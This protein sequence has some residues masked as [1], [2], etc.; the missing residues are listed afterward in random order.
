MTAQTVE[1][2]SEHGVLSIHTSRQGVASKV[3]HD[4]RIEPT[5]WTAT[6]TLPDGD[7]TK[8]SVRLVADA[9]SLRV[10]EGSGGAKALSDSDRADI[11][12]NMHNKQLLTDRHP[13][14]VFEST[15]V[16]NVSA[17][18][19]P[20]T[21]T[22][23]GQLTVLGRSSPVSVDVSVEPSNGGYRVTASGVVRQTDWGIKPYSAFLGALKVK[24]E[25]DVRFVAEFKLP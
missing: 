15:S 5:N 18:E 10:R 23:Q 19:P 7:L 8:A 11:E 17:P 14:I 20:A 12:K 24:D 4:L 1:L 6:V 9:R 3:G 13:E 2:S 25:V 22:L 21:G 16:S